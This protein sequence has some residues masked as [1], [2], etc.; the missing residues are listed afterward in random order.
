[1]QIYRLVYASEGALIGTEAHIRKQI[2]EIVVGSVAR[3]AASDLTGAIMQTRTGFI[4]VL[5]GPLS[6]LEEAFERICRDLR[7][8]QIDLLEFTPVDSRTFDRWAMAL[9]TPSRAIGRLIS[10]SDFCDVHKKD[11]I[12]PQ[13]VMQLMQTILLV[14]QGTNAA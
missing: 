7:H 1:M 6:A 2:D 10:A 11:K 9:V 12:S 5:E 14:Q 8:R 3:N 4:Q 13:P